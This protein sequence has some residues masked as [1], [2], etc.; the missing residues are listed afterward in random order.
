MVAKASPKRVV[1]VMSKDMIEIF[2]FHAKSDLVDNYRELFTKFN[3]KGTGHISAAELQM[4]L[5]K[6]LE[7]SVKVSNKEAASMVKVGDVDG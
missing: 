3:T 1:Q 4:G 2:G 6:L 5:M 7:P